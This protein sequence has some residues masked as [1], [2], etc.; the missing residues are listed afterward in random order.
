[1]LRW[2]FPFIFIL[3][4]STSAYSG[5]IHAY[6]GIPSQESY[7]ER[8]GYIIQYDFQRKTPKW[9][10]WHV[11]PEWLNTPPRKGKYGKFRD[12]PEVT[13]EATT[14][15]YKKQFNTWRNYAKGHIAPY[16]ISGGD[17]DNDGVLALDDD[18]EDLKTVY[19]VMYM[20]N[21]AP[22]H[23]YHFNGT[24]GLWYRLETWVRETVLKKEQKEVWVFAGTIYGA[25]QYDQIG[26]GVEVPAMFWKM[27]ITETE[28]KP[29]VLAFLFPHQIYKHGDI[30]DFLVS[31]NLIEAMTGLDFFPE[32]N[33]EEMERKSTFEN[34]K[35]E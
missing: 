12:D 13:G 24:G 5:S 11:K 29:K 32:I 31:V 20:S 7:M 2:L 17:R 1:M 9:V 18:P 23:H 10:A 14:A 27:V 8:N 25:G 3:I 22:Q 34:W 16:Y 33:D 30:E 26:D 21:M 4:F 15:D 6:G 19:E 35:T 28:G